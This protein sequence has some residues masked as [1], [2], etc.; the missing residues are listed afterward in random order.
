MKKYIILL[1]IIVFLY[2]YNFNEDFKNYENMKKS[3]NNKNWITYSANNIEKNKYTLTLKNKTLFDGEIKIKNKLKYY[4]TNNKLIAFQI[5]DYEISVKGIYKDKEYTIIFSRELERIKINI[6]SDNIV[7]TGYGTN[8][9]YSYPWF[10]ILPLVFKNGSDNVAL[11]EYNSS[12]GNYNPLTINVNKKYN[13]YLIFIFQT[14]M[15]L[16][17]YVSIL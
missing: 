9:D 5:S 11:I 3:I 1:I 14:Y 13:H 8:N 15:M 17:S 10:Y 12:F 6:P 16:Y 7:I 4:Y 2:F